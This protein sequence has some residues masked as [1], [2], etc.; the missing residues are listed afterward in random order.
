MKK[1]KL[2]IKV[3]YLIFAIQIFGMVSIQMVYAQDNYIVLPKTIK[4]DAQQDVNINTLKI[5]RK[6]GPEADSVL[7]DLAKRMEDIDKT[8]KERKDSLT[9]VQ[10]DA[11]I[12]ARNLIVENLAD[13]QNILTNTSGGEFPSEK[14][15]KIDGYIAEIKKYLSAPPKK[16][17]VRSEIEY[18]GLSAKKMAILFQSYAKSVAKSKEWSTYTAGETMQVGTYVF[19]VKEPNMD[20]RCEETVPV[21]NDPT[22][23]KIC[24]GFNP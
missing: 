6:V 17:N 1:S 2:K 3:S 5:P 24:G 21:L 16:D 20:K 11:L 19:V 14:K 22:K 8:V 13:G 7:I 15:Q 23:R 4:A 18:G 9:Q 12:E 10:L